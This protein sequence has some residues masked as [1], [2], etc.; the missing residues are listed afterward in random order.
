M[1]HL[2]DKLTGDKCYPL[3]VDMIF[4]NIKNDVE[5]GLIWKIKLMDNSFGPK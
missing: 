4:G 5:P 2:W 3:W 1:G